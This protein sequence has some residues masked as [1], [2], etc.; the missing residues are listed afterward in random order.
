MLQ[1]PRPSPQASQHRYVLLCPPANVVLCQCLHNLVCVLGGQQ[2]L[3][4][5]LLPLHH[6]LKL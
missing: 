4:Y 2:A 1:L 6:L 3:E 5:A